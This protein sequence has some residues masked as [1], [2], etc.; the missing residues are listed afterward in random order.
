ML[1]AGELTEASRSLRSAAHLVRQ[2][3]H[4]GESHRHAIAAAGFSGEAAEAGLK[5]MEK[6]TKAFDK[7]AYRLNCVAL[8]LEQTAGLQKGLDFQLGIIKMT[9]FPPPYSL[10]K[11]Q[12]LAEIRIAAV[13]LDLACAKMVQEFYKTEH[14]ANLDRL[15][16]HPG[17]SLAD[18]HARHTGTAP[19]AVVDAVNDVG[20]VFLESGPSGHT[21]I[22]P[23]RCAQDGWA[24]SPEH[25][26][27]MVSGVTSGKPEKF[28][29]TLE[30]AQRLADATGAP[31]IVWQGYAAPPSLIDGV[32]RSPSLSGAD[33]LSVFQM[34]LAERY[35]EAK[36]TVFGHSYGTTV[37]TNAAER[38]LHA[39]ELV[40]AGSPGVPVGHVSDMTLIGSDPATTPRVTVADSPNDI[41]NHTRGGPFALHGTNPGHKSFGAEQMPDIEAGHTGYL[42][43]RAFLRGMREVVRR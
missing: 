16:F 18:I 5:R 27:T 12:L 26:T 10:L 17:E 39:D 6:L 4:A 29:G 22:V 36:K 11:Q 38:G 34:E 2:R 43:D 20:G 30:N 15:A 1:V 3:Q 42:D 41:I 24:L 37:V 35:P 40:I 14:E 32:S 25:I 7:P 31:V 28:P 21:V 9:P 8:I 23:P 19:A 13:A 33:D